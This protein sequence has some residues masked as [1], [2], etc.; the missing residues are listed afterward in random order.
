MKV[1]SSST[2]TGR[3]WG[4]QGKWPG[5]GGGSAGVLAERSEDAG[6]I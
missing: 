5:G 4:L 2:V 6:A 1:D 3:E